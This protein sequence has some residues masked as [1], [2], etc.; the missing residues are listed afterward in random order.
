M[1]NE[2]VIEGFCLEIS[3]MVEFPF[4][5]KWEAG[6]W[7]QGIF[8]ILFCI[9][10]TSYVNFIL[11]AT[12]SRFFS[13][14]CKLIKVTNWLSTYLHIIFRSGPFYFMWRYRSA[15]SLQRQ[16]RLSDS[17]VEIFDL[18]HSNLFAIALSSHFKRIVNCYYIALWD[19]ISSIYSSSM[20]FSW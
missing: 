11:D 9:L 20:A 3:P 15:S 6:V 5:E 7:N 1:R 12:I 18:V 16:Q 2:S 8:R 17:S 4:R 14:R 19:L 10:L 13:P